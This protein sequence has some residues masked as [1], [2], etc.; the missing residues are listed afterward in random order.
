MPVRS[1]P[2]IETTD[3]EEKMSALPGTTGRR[4]IYLMRHGHVDYFAKEVVD[5]GDPRLARLTE[6]GE[7][8]A[9]AAGD[10]LSDVS[11]D[12]AICSG[13][14]RSEQT[15]QIVLSYQRD[16]APELESDPRFEELNS[17][18]FIHFESREQLA[19]TMS[20][21]FENANA[22]GATFLEGGERFTD[23]LDRAV[24]AIKTL[25]ARPG[26]SQ[27]LIVGHE[28]I[29]RVILSW[30]CNAELNATLAFE[31]DT[32]CINILDLDLVPSEKNDAVEIERKLI[33]SV[34][35]TPL[36]YQKHGMNLRSFEAIFR[37]HDPIG[38]D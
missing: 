2:D 7:E 19:A 18:T 34:N 31:Q 14:L 37:Q 16:R 9:S 24:Q 6:Q 4:R 11:F 29:N 36:N 3:P 1:R 35:L 26:W 17:G 27:A 15:A 33:K 22:P 25:I 28:G 20:F 12:L 13:L 21:Q 30:I 23:G 8:E 5:T 32:G 10:A 38:D